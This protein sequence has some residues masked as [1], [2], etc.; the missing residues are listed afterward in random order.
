MLAEG[1]GKKSMIVGGILIGGMSMK[2]VEM[3][4]I[5][6]VVVEIISRNLLQVANI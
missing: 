6:I 1:Q 2:I 5:M 3:R 4:I